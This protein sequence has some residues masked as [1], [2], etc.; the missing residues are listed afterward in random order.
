MDDDILTRLHVTNE[1]IAAFCRKWQITRF[2]LFGSALRDDFDDES[3]VDVLV[4]FADG[5][6]V[7]LTDLLDME[8]E[9]QL[10]FG[11]K[12]DLIKRHLVEESRNWIRRRNI[13]ESA[14][15]IYAAS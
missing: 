13:L 6:P 5:R 12:V 9:L 8:E 15:L 14:R 4:V 10:L 3:D 11:R 1:Q 2:E 7:G